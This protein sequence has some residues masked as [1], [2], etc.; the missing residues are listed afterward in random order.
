MWMCGH[1]CFYDLS[2]DTARVY[3]AHVSGHLPVNICVSVSMYMHHECVYMC[4]YVHFY[5]LVHAYV[6][7]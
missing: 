5:A 7:V 4:P 2:E 3:G 6:H 1:V